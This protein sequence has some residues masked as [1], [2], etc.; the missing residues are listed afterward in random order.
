[1]R[2]M[3]A[4]QLAFYRELKREDGPLTRAELYDEYNPKLYY[5]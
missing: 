5:L 3:P 4:D 1:M 2:T